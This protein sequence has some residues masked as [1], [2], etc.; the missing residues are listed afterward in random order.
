MDAGNRGV[1]SSAPIS[2][3]SQELAIGAL[4][5]PVWSLGGSL[6]PVLCGGRDAATMG[7]ISFWRH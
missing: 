2:R 5:S 6:K 1:A 4:P 7:E 3:H